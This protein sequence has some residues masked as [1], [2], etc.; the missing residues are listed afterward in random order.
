MTTYFSHINAATRM[1][2]WHIRN[3]SHLFS[4]MHPQS[5]W[6]PPCSLSQSHSSP[7]LPAATHY[8]H[9]YCDTVLILNHCHTLFFTQSRSPSVF[10]KQD[11]YSPTKTELRW[12]QLCF[13][14]CLH[15]L[16][17]FIHGTPDNPWHCTG[18][19]TLRLLSSSRSHLTP[20]PPTRALSLI[21]I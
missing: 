16:H 1:L 8:T 15:I 14:Q 7:T 20:T 18:M 13:S 12:Q 6:H 2:S 4:S 5:L 11:I 9:N 17:F 10:L 19:V 3:L 21:H